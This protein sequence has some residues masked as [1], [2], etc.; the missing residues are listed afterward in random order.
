MIKR[1]RKYL[2]SVL[3][4]GIFSIFFSSFNAQKYLLE[5]GYYFSDGEKKFAHLWVGDEECQK[6]LEIKSRANICC[7]S[8]DSL[9]VSKSDRPELFKSIADTIDLETQYHNN[10]FSAYS[11]FL[12]ANYQYHVGPKLS[13]IVKGLGFNMRDD[14]MQDLAISFNFKGTEAVSSESSRMGSLD[15]SLGL[16]KKSPGISMGFGSEDK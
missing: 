7:Y 8:R 11:S 9:Q 5:V 15:D 1:F 14:E 2:L 13:E 10:F 3:V 12:C 16:G 4:M 6:L